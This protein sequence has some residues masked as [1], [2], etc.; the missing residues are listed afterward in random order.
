MATRKTAWMSPLEARDWA[1][2][3]PETTEQS[4]MGRPDIRVR[5]KIFLTLG[6]DGTTVNLKSSPLNLSLLVSSDPATFRDVWGGRGVG[7]SVA[8]ITADR[9]C[10]LIVDAWCLA[11]PR[12]LVRAHPGLGGA[13][14]PLL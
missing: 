2:T 13:D 1:L 8:R 6:T 9:L 7:V 12:A 3:L 5:N 11:A 10:R 14:G 4:H